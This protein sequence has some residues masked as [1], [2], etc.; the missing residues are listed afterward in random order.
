MTIVSAAA[1]PVYTHGQQTR[2]TAVLLALCTLVI[3]ALALMW[4]RRR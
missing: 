2:G 3:A 4:W 1:L